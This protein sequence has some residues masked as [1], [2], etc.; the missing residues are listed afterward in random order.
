M[1]RKP[2]ASAHQKVLDAAFELTAERGVDGTGMDAIAEASGV[3]KAAIYKH[4]ATKTR[5]AETSPSARIN[6]GELSTKI[7]LDLTYAASWPDDLLVHLSEKI[8]RNP[9]GLAEG[10]SQR[11]LESLQHEQRRSKN[12]GFGSSLLVSSVHSISSAMDLLSNF[13][14]TKWTQGRRHRPRLE[15]DRMISAPKR[16]NEPN[17][18]R[19][20]KTP[21]TRKPPLSF[22]G[23]DK[24]QKFSISL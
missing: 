12:A 22:G 8:G 20:V 7:D 5:C 11:I 13:G 18:V 15:L 2:S 19:L 23:R 21:L 14:A 9:K 4:W 1:A 17:R 16:K 10:R 6:K 24:S 3:S